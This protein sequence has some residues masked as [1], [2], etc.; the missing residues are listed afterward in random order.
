M[1][2]GIGLGGSVRM[3][4][5]LAAPSD[6][7]RPLAPDARIRYNGGGEGLTPMT[8]VFGL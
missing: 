2:P 1:F 8:A 6:G 4:S 5:P 7:I 3:G